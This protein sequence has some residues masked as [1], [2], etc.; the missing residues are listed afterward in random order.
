MNTGMV[1][2]LMENF[3]TFQGTF[4]CDLLP[5]SK[6]GM[7]FIVNTETSRENGQHWVAVYIS[8]KT[9][10][11]FD[12]FGRSIEQFPDP[13]KMYMQASSKGFDVC[14]SKRHLQLLTSTSCG[15][16][17]LYYLY[18]KHMDYKSIFAPFSTNNVTNEIKLHHIMQ[19]LLEILPYYL[20]NMFKI[21][22]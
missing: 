1:N 4:P 6:A 3:P 22:Q 13:F 21:S 7:S 5:K 17:C 15:N 20:E 14:T 11:V 10:Y 9:Y 18:C 19:F 16:W 2:K 8:Q 12:S